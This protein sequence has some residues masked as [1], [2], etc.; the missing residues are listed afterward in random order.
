M[1]KIQL[2]EGLQ[3][4]R[5][6]HGMMRLNEWD[7][8]KE[9]RLT[10]F[11]EVM[12]LG[13]TSFDHADIYGSYTCEELFGE[14]IALEPSLRSNMELI[15]KCGIV[16][17]SKN[18]PEHESHH[19]NTSK[20]HIVKSVERSL[21][22]LSTDY[23]DL[24]LI[25]RPDPLMNP[26]EVAQAFDEL[27]RSGKVRH[28][29]VSNFKRS[30]L[31]MLESYVSQPLVT[32]QIELN[33]FNLE[34]FS[35]GTVELMQEKRLPSMAWSPLAGGDLLKG[36]SE[37]A[38]RLR[39]ALEEVGDELGTEEIDQV[40]YAWLYTHPSTILPIVGSGKMSRI[41][42]AIKA[43]DYKMTPHQ[44]FHIYQASLGH[45]VP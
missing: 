27:H 26:E 4:S 20:E 41:K 32:N 9:E 22:N 17:E 5:V 14:A 38:L 19:Y 28:F 8:S 37:K 31:S 10:F 25:H 24:L 6:V 18:R 15:S 16:L 43:K 40:L 21:K 44:W 13:I 11:K 36:Q 7:L 30:Q 2:A 33:P 29:G 45:D 1:E 39:K 35:D 34:N 23:L 42:S 12:D 3:L